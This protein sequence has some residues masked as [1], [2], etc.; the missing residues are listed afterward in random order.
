MYAAT[1]HQPTDRERRGAVNCGGFGPIF[2]VQ[3]TA[4]RR[5]VLTHCVILK[6]FQD[7]QV[8]YSK[9]LDLGIGIDW[10]WVGFEKRCELCFVGI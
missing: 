8:D 10:R 2:A 6:N 7:G 9:N 4:P 1:R 5:L 3:N